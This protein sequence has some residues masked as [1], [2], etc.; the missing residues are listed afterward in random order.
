MDLAETE[1]LST[2]Y[3]GNHHSGPASD[4][5]ATQS[6]RLE[7]LGDPGLYASGL[8]HSESVYLYSDLWNSGTA[9]PQYDQE[10]AFLDVVQPL[11]HREKLTATQSLWKESHHSTNAEAGFSEP[12]I[13]LEDLESRYLPQRP[14]ETFET[15]ILLQQSFGSDTVSKSIQESNNQQCNENQKS[16]IIS[17]SHSANPEATYLLLGIE[18]EADKDLQLNAISSSTTDIK[19]EAGTKYGRKAPLTPEQRSRA[20]HMRKTGACLRC[21]LMKSSVSSISFLLWHTR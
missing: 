7:T 17:Q 15:S 8:G 1:G 3:N 10:M 9:V 19:L 11:P 21:R 20:C 13:A 5:E 2:T 16:N 6:T 18:E 4:D 14:T 12:F